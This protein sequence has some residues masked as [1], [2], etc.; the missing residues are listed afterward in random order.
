MTSSISSNI[1]ELWPGVLYKGA[2]LTRGLPTFV[3]AN[4]SEGAVTA[5]HSML[6][7]DSRTFWHIKEFKTQIENKSKSSCLHHHARYLV[8]YVFA[9]TLRL[10]FVRC[11]ALHYDQTS[12]LWFGRTLFQKSWGLLKGNFAEL[13][14]MFGEKGLSFNNWF[15]YCCTCWVFH[16]IPLLLP[17]RFNLQRSVALTLHFVLNLLWCLLV[18][19]WEVELNTMEWWNGYEMV[20][21]GQQ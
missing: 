5:C 2:S 14:S 12:P 16:Q 10:V 13:H 8:Y 21:H 9:A 6:T 15:P 1:E 17:L 4:L 19:R 7:F 3:H 20:V 11:G 18:G